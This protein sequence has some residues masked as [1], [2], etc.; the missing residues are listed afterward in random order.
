[1]ELISPDEPSLNT[2]NQWISL[3]QCNGGVIKLFAPN[4]ASPQNHSVDTTEVWA[5]F[6]RPLDESIKLRM[7]ETY[8]NTE[9]LRVIILESFDVTRELKTFKTTEYINIDKNSDLIFEHKLHVRSEAAN[10]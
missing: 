2:E 5:L 9:A 1:M 6:S 8:E 4:S 10:S 7:N 3:H